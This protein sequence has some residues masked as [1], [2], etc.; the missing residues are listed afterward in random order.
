MPFSRAHNFLR[1]ANRGESFPV[2]CTLP[3]P[4][5]PYANTVALYPLKRPSTSGSTQLSYSL[6]S[7]KPAP[8]KTWSYV[9]LF[10]PV[11]TCSIRATMR[12]F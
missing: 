4:V 2:T 7:G 9:K 5:W 3:D 12:S 11:N 1:G 8:P 10:A 6:A